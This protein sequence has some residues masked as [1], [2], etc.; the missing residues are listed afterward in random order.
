MVN[1]HPI[2][3]FLQQQVTAKE[4]AIKAEKA[5]G[6]PSFNLGVNAQTL[7]KAKYFYYG[8]VGINIPIFKNGVKARTQAARFETEI[9]KKELDKTQQE[10]STIFLQQNQLQQQ[11]LQQLKYYQ[12]EGLPMAESIINAA[13][14]SYKA[15]DI[16]YIE[17][18]QNIK[19]AIKIKTD[20]LAA[21]NSYNQ[22]II[23]L[24]YLLNR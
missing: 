5:K 13:Q 11:R 18:I 1:K 23:Q 4:L 22:T 10:I 16:G 19:D 6:Q 9:A 2:L 12:T 14:R 24:N 21:I 3:Q 7:D 17:Y 20:Y 15:G 8:G